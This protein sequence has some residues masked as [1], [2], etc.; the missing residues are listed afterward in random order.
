MGSEKVSTTLPPN[1]PSIEISRANYGETE[2][3]PDGGRGWLQVFVGHLALFN[4]VGWFNSYG[5]FQQYYTSELGLS[6]SAI[7]WTGS[8]QVFF[9]TLVGAFSGRMFDAGYFRSLVVG[10]SL[11]QILGVFMASIAT[12][13]WQLFLAQGV[14]GGLGAGI[15]YCPMIACIAT[16]FSKKRALAIALVTSGSATGGVAYPLI[17]QQLPSKVGFPWTMR[18]MGFIMLFNA[19]IMLIWARSRLPPRPRGPLI[20]WAAFREL[21]FTLYTIGVFCLLL[22]VYLIYNYINHYGETVVGMD[23]GA[24]LTPLFIAN[25]MGLPGRLVPGMLSDAYFGPFRT[26]VPLA[27]TSGILYFGWIGIRDSGSLF[28]FAVLEGFINGGPPVAGAL[29]DAAD[30]DYLYMQIWAGSVMIL[31][32]CFIQVTT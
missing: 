14:C 24:S 10:G 25:A 18:I 27:I 20:E 2:A 5:I 30:G 9:L 31:G 13:Y 3:P 17:A 6:L 23:R 21:P 12:Q 1:R 19:V 29:V 32:A 15:V 28:A 11:L 22:S 26:L 16:Y 7:S 8:I 4:T